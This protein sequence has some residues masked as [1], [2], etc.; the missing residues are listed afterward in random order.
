MT[1]SKTSLPNLGRLKSGFL[2]TKQLIKT[3][4]VNFKYTKNS[5]VN[6]I[7]FCKFFYYKNFDVKF[8]IHYFDCVESP[9]R[10]LK[11]LM[12]N[13]KNTWKLTFAVLFLAAL[14]AF[15][16][17]LQ[18]NFHGAKAT[19]AEERLA[20]IEVEITEDYFAT[21]ESNYFSTDDII[22]DAGDSSQTAMIGFNF[23]FNEPL[24][25]NQVILTQLI[26]ALIC[27]LIATK[28]QIETR[29]YE[30]FN[31]DDQGMVLF[32]NSTAEITHN[33]TIYTGMIFKAVGIA[34]GFLSLFVYVF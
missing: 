33:L 19:H 11:L 21:N 6:K 32:E 18:L 3:F 25:K 12:N 17:M 29:I 14:T 16:V 4:S 1:G 23:P 9:K 13:L 28:F 20:Y 2:R 22:N 8:F 7:L 27:L 31:K 15:V 30:F 34:C 10:T 24:S 26:L 5:L